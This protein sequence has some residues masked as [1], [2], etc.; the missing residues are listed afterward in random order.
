MSAITVEIFIKADGVPLFLPFSYKD[1]QC[2]KMLIV[3]YNDYFFIFFVA[4]YK[5]IVYNVIRNS[6]ISE[7]WGVSDNVM[8]LRIK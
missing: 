3:G 8:L 2:Y 7:K 5:I 6:N 4:F 1:S